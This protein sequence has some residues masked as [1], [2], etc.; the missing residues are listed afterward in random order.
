EL[1]PYRRPVDVDE[2]AWAAFM[3]R[4]PTDAGRFRPFDPVRETTI[5]AGRLRHATH[6]AALASGPP[7]WPEA[8]IASFVL[9]HGEPRGGTHAPPGKRR[10]AYLPLPTIHA[11]GSGA[12]R[13][14]AMRRVLLTTFADDCHGEVGWAELALAGQELVDEATKAS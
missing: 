11:R 4:V 14:G 12:E 10:F 1:R 6:K 8:K 3:L 7:A 5:T 9:G 2:R 13:L